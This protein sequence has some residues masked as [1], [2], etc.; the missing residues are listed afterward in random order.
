MLHTP[1]TRVVTSLDAALVRRDVLLEHWAMC[2]FSHPG[3]LEG[4]WYTFKATMSSRHI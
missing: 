1:P 2:N 4:A 3:E